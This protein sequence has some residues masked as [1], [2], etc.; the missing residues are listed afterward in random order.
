MKRTIWI[1]LAVGSVALGA[2]ADPVATCTLRWLSSAEFS[3]TG[4]YLAVGTHYAVVLYEPGEWKE[5]MRLPF[6]EMSVSALAFSPDG[7]RLAAGALNEVRVWEVPTGDLLATVNGPFGRVLGMAFGPEGTLLIGGSDGSLR[8]WDL[9]RGEAMWV[10]TPH[11]VQVR[12][13]AC[14]RDGTLMA[15]AGHDRAILWDTATWTE[16]RSLPGKA[17]DV[18]FTPDGYFLVVGWGKI[19][20]VWDTAVGLLYHNELWGHE[21]CAITVAVSPDGRLLLSGSLDETARV[22]DAETGACLAVLDGHGAVVQAVGFS[23]DG[24]LIVTA[25]D[26]GLVHIWDASEILAAP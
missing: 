21:S 18:A 11:T 17:W 22:W 12:E 7:A 19:L 15:S 14:S 1:A 20:R 5:V 8:L 24:S 6:P 26:N 2:P 25:S 4:G 3:P 13:I 23:P 9:A 10:K 16:L